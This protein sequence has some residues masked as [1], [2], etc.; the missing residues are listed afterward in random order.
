M[1]ALLVILGT[2]SG[3]MSLQ[4]DAGAQGC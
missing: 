4:R 1:G 2:G 3:P